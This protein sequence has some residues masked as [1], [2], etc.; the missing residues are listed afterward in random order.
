M[1]QSVDREKRPR[2]WVGSMWLASVGCKW[3]RLW[4]LKSMAMAEAKW[5]GL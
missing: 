5:T 2:L 4:R 3:M 1:R